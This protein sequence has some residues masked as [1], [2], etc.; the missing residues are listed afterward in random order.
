MT[1]MALGQLLNLLLNTTKRA[2]K[3]TPVKTPGPDR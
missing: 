2:H 3:K 1:I